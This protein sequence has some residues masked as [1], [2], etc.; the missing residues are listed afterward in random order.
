[1]AQIE[2]SQCDGTGYMES[3]P[4]DPNIIGHWVGACIWCDGK[5]YLEYGDE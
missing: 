4:H 1:M 5:G 2:C 3:I